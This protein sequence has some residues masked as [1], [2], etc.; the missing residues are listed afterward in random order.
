MA[1][2]TLYLCGIQDTPGNGLVDV[3]DAETFEFLYRMTGDPADT[4]IYFVSSI[5]EHVPS[6]RIY[7]MLFANPGGFGYSDKIQVNAADGSWL[8]SFDIVR[9]GL[10]TLAVDGENAIYIIYATGNISVP[11]EQT[12]I[13]RYNHLGVETGSWV[14]ANS[15]FDNS[16]LLV[17]GDTAYIVLSNGYANSIKA[18]DL[19]TSTY[20][21]DLYTSDDYIDVISFTLA[22]DICVARAS[23]SPIGVPMGATFW[24]IN[25]S[26][27]LLKTIPGSYIYWLTYRKF[28]FWAG[29]STSDGYTTGYS[30]TCDPSIDV[31]LANPFIFADIG[32]VTGPDVEGTCPI[33]WVGGGVFRLDPAQLVDTY[34]TAPP[35]TVDEAIPNPF[36]ETYL[37]GDE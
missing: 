28:W 12:I 5:V 24:I 18:Y 9:A 14:V 23:T 31:V 15:R 27:T 20:L 33:P 3:Y 32:M 6:G 8:Y 17:S 25:T 1:T 4:D 2:H 36:A 37:I 21:P 34:Y 29:K 7:S 35:D 19:G 30:T 11:P 22:G 13:K 16:H 26:G 10:S